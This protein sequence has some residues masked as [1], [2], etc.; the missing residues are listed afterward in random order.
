MLER[1]S[2]G[3]AGFGGV[4]VV[5][6]VGVVV[7]V[8]VVVIVFAIVLVVTLDIVVVVV[9][10]PGVVVT[11]VVVLQAIVISESA[12]NPTPNSG[13][14]RKILLDKKCFTDSPFDFIYFLS[15]K[16]GVLRD[17]QKQQ[18]C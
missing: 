1:I 6:V 5:E 16:K 18:A 13:R 11:E 14:Q 10:V 9:V 3:F 12:I 17:A 7:A 4:V 15:N 8:V 2:S